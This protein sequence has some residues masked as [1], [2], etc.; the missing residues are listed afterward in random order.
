M[1]PKT[2]EWFADELQGDEKMRLRPAE[3]ED[4]GYALEVM[5]LEKREKKWYEPNGEEYY[6]SS[7]FLVYAFIGDNY[8]DDSFWGLRIFMKL[9]GVW[10]LVY[11]IPE[12][13]V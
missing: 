8:I 11:E 6:D 1:D 13:T 3:D 10:T 4:F 5:G 9:T 2:P 12:D 7:D